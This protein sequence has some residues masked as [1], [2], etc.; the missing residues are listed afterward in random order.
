VILHVRPISTSEVVTNQ[1]FRNL[2]NIEETDYNAPILENRELFLK[3]KDKMQKD[4]ILMPTEQSSFK[5]R[6]FSLLA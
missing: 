2:K 6:G 3:M 5:E 1:K 4:E